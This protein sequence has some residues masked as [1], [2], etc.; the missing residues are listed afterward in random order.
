MKIEL[1]E[2]AQF[3]C[4]FYAV[5]LAIVFLISMAMYC[6]YLTTTSAF[7]HGYQE[8]DRVGNEGT[9]WIKKP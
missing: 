6:S 2:E 9:I 4:C 3:I 5:T 7:A 8:A 1:N